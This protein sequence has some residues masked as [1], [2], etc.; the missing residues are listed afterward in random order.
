MKPCPAALGV[1]ADAGVVSGRSDEDQLAVDSGC[2]AR[3]YTAAAVHGTPDSSG[4]VRMLVDPDT[5]G[6]LVWASSRV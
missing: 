5:A 3:V 1:A 2:S 4:S 6:P